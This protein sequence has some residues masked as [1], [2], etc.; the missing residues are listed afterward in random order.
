VAVVDDGVN[1]N[2]P[3]LTSNFNVA[4]SYDFMKDRN[5]SRSYSP[6]R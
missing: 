3:D 6:G 4:S 1:M 2:H 5:I